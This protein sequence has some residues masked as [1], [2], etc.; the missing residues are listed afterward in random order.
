MSNVARDE[1]CDD[2][3]SAIAGARGLSHQD[4]DQLLLLYGQITGRESLQNAAGIRA[5]IGSTGHPD[6]LDPCHEIWP[7]VSYP[8]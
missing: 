8:P 3:E 4:Q 2:V 1:H 6:E 7:G 5:Q